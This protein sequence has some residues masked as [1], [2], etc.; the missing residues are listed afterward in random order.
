MSQRAKEIFSIFLSAAA[1]LGVFCFLFLGQGWNLILCMALAAVLYLALTLIL[2]PSVRIGRT[3]FS[4]E[5][6]GEH[7][8]SRLARGG[9]GLPADGEGRR[10]NPGCQ[11]AGKVR[12]AFAHG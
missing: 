10:E 9:R 7:L 12:R 6:K 2:K 1:A 5:E 4:Q 11:H 8:Q 3:A